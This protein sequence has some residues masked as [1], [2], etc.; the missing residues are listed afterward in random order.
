VEIDEAYAQQHV[1]M[2]PGPYVMLSVRD[3]GTGM[4]LKTQAQIFDPFFTTKDFGKGTG[5]GLSTVFGI[6]K[7]SGGTIGVYSEPGKG[8]AFKIHF[9]RCDKVPMIVEPIKPNQL[10]GGTET[11]LLVDDATP[12]RML[13]KLI[14]E[15][16]GYTCSLR[17]SLQKLFGW[18]KVTKDYCR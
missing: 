9:P 7:Q 15:Q 6:V 1:P 14:L 4:D 2:N 12:L 16:C 11:I 3:T 5:L 8:T 17:E 10:R 13:T 18:R